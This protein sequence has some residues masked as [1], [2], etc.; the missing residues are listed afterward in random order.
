[1][2][3]TI[4]QIAQSLGAEAAGDLE[5]TVTRASEPADATADALALAMSPKYAE[6]LSAGNAEAAVVW[7]DADWRAMGLKA[8][9]F[10]P[11]PRMAMAGVTVMMDAGQGEGQG[12]HPSAV[13]D[14]TARIGENVSIGPLCVIGANAVIGNGSVIGPHCVVGIDVKLGENAHLREMVSIG[15][16]ATIGDRF[17]AQP[18]VRIGSD[19]FSFVT[20]EVSGVENARKSMGDS[21]D[22]KAQ[23]WM[24]IHSIGAVEIGDDVEIGANSTI[25]N[26]TIR[27]TVIGSGTKLDNL[28]HVG[29]N[30]RVGQDCLLCGQVGLSGSVEIGNNTVLGG[31]VGVADNL[32]LG[33]GVIAAGATKILS[34]VPDGRVMMGYPAVKM[35]THTEIYKAQRRLPRILR[36]VDALKKA[37][38]K[39]TSSD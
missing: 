11:R 8:A 24:R 4:Q 35:E 39:L 22:A 32:F 26:G 7:P 10:A 29:H 3:F 28:V 13:V 18:G 23:S 19:G 12:I 6:E 34:N 20:P 36:D 27:N 38:S 37:V 17:R 2:R 16:R 31:Q 33:A 9:I 14:P 30:S 21:G 5:L 25:D 15:A 1:M